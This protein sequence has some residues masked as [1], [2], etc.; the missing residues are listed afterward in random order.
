MQYWLSTELSAAISMYEDKTT[1][2]PC[3]QEDFSL[4][5]NWTYALKKLIM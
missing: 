2:R 4:L 3:T 1:W 5:G